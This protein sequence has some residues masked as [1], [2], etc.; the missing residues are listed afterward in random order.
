VLN[1]LHVKPIR[2]GQ[3]QRFST[4]WAMSKGVQPFV[5]G[6]KRSGKVA[7]VGAGPAGLACAA[8]L[9]RLGIEATV[10][11]ANREPGGLNTYG[12][13][14]Y[15][16]TPEF[17]LR[18]VKWL[19]EA[20]VKVKSGVRVGKDI[21]IAE[22]EKTHDAIFIGVGLG[23]VH[24]LGIPGEDL[25]GVHDAVELIAQ[26]KTERDK[27]RL[28][29]RVAVIGGGNTA[30]DVVTQASALGA[31]E[32]TLVY[33]R[34]LEE[35]PAYK[36]EVALAKEWGCRFVFLA[37]PMRIVGNNKVEGLELER[38]KLGKPDSTGR[39]KPEPTGEK[40]RLAVDAVVASTGQAPQSEFL[41]SLNIQL[42]HG[43]VLVDERTMQTSN[44]KYFAGGDCTSG[45]KEVVNAVAEGKRAA[46]GIVAML[47]AKVKR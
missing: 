32:V 43:R 7:V 42:D 29:K 23:K 14:Q 39:K 5:A 20:G 1:D 15:K 31:E 47:D 10:Y 44:A 22:L 19:L 40:F 46:Q 26:I 28:G 17:A 30:I 9:L 38:M 34:G 3:L 6:P 25:P 24:K 18:E 36:H 11:D 35:M 16:M 8:E 33:R 12:V 4:D 2:I 37:A 21:S 27:L 41:K 13:A 45:G